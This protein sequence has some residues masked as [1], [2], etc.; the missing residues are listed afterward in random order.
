MNVFQFFI[1]FKRTNNANNAA[2]YVK[3]GTKR[4]E[5][6]KR[7]YYTISPWV[8]IKAIIIKATSSSLQLLVFLDFPSDNGL[9]WPGSARGPEQSL[10]WSRYKCIFPAQTCKNIKLNAVC[11]LKQNGTKIYGLR[12]TLFDSFSYHAPPAWPLFLSAWLEFL[13]RGEFFK[14]LFS[15]WAPQ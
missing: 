12:E 8:I 6:S 11:G 1:S 9:K 2:H 4:R 13:E 15:E 5:S 3:L 7:D 14:H 10:E